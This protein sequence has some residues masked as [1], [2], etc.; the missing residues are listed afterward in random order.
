M[1]SPIIIIG[2]VLIAAV[3]IGLKLMRR[4]PADSANKPNR[5]RVPI[6]L[7][8]VGIIALLAGRWLLTAGNNHP[9]IGLCIAALASAVAIFMSSRYLKFADWLPYVWLGAA[10]LLAWVSSIPGIIVQPGSFLTAFGNGKILALASL[11][12]LAGAVIMAL[13]KSSGAAWFAIVV[14]AVFMIVPKVYEPYKH[15]ERHTITVERGG[16]K[17][18]YGIAQFRQGVVTVDASTPRGPDG[19]YS[20]FGLQSDGYNRTIRLQDWQAVELWVTGSPQKD[21]DR[22]EIKLA[23]GRWVR[24]FVGGQNGLKGPVEECD[25]EVRI[26][27]DVQTGLLK[28]GMKIYTRR[29]S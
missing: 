14:A 4:K 19:I 17:A 3:L 28:F 8:V 5:W 27:P 10:I 12:F 29:T 1:K 26:P 15:P 25:L 6:I 20:V 18:N 23:P 13:F 9:Q 2:F 11:V 22:L 21:L 7:V 24:P 16:E